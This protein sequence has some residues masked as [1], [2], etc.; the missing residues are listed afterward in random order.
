[1]VSSGLLVALD[2]HGILR[3]KEQDLIVYLL[4]LDPRK[5]VPHLF[6]RLAVPDVN[7]DRHLLQFCRFLQTRQLHELFKQRDRKIIHT[8]VS[9]IF[10]H[11]NCRTFS[12]PGHSG[13]NYELHASHSPFL[14]ILL[15]SLSIGLKFASILISGSSFT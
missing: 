6:Q 5:H 11:L 3:I 15:L 12:G 10:H 4:F 13:Q 14:R 9:D 8:I 2:Q 7:T 1:M